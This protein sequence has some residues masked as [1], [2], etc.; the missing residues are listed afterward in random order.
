MARIL[1]ELHPNGEF[2]FRTKLRWTK[3]TLKRKASL[4]LAKLA[5]GKA[6]GARAL[7]NKFEFQEPFLGKCLRMAS[8]GKG[9]K[10]GWGLVPGKTRFGVRGRR[11]IL[12]SGGVMDSLPGVRAAIT[13][14]LPGSGERAYKAIAAWS[15]Y[16]AN[17]VKTWLYDQ[18]EGQKEIAYFYVWELQ[19]RGAL[20]MHLCLN[21][22]SHSEF[23]RIKKGI[24]NEWI[25]IIEDVMERSGTHMFLSPK[26]VDNRRRKKSIQ[27]DCQKVRKSVSAYFAKYCG[28]QD[29]GALEHIENG[30]RPSRWWGCSRWLSR[31]TKAR[32][33]HLMTFEMSQEQIDLLL[34]KTMDAL[35]DVDACYMKTNPYT[36]QHYL[37][38]YPGVG[39]GME[40]IKELEFQFSRNKSC[41]IEAHVGGDYMLD[42]RVRKI[43]RRFNSQD[44]RY[45]LAEIFGTDSYEWELFIYLMR[46]PD[47]IPPQMVDQLLQ[48]IEDEGG[49]PDEEAEDEDAFYIPLQLNLRNL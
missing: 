11:L 17:R 30:F 4:K 18:I 25:K 7:D 44:E 35:E 15:G 36:G 1:A 24:K 8:Q 3:Q 31:E 47:A 29:K 45:R 6:L 33:V 14:T 42:Q 19:K 43:R 28:K 5:E 23:S 34:E 10:S 20:H 48:I 26:G 12:R 49:V 38:A 13:L 16:V 39:L 41:R 21:C 37:I 32:R 2:R 22:G 40:L 27:V 46:D 9:L